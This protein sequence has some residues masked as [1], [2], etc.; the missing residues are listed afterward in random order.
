LVGP[1][2][3]CLSAK[4]LAALKHKVRD[5]NDGIRREPEMPEHEDVVIKAPL[6]ENEFDAV[7]GESDTDAYRQQP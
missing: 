1:R 4:L 3:F 7:P 5:Q 2:R 6:A